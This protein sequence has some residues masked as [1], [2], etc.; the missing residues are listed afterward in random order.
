MFSGCLTSLTSAN[1]QNPSSFQNCTVK[2]DFPTSRFSRKLEELQPIANLGLPLQILV[3]I[4]NCS[5][6][7]A[8]VAKSQGRTHQQHQHHQ[9]GWGHGR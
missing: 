7:A 6:A 2:L 9:W 8:A 5:P 4:L 1:D 3:Q